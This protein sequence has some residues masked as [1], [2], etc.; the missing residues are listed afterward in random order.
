MSTFM[1]EV[2]DNSEDA[3]E[4]DLL[5]YDKYKEQ[6]KENIIQKFLY[7]NEQKLLKKNYILELVKDT[8]L[9]PYV[10]EMEHLIG[11][12]EGIAFTD[13]PTR[14]LSRFF[15]PKINA[16]IQQSQTDSFLDATNVALGV[17][18][19]F[20]TNYTIQDILNFNVFRYKTK[21]A[22]PDKN[23]LP[24]YV[25]SYLL[26]RNG[27]EPEDNY[28]MFSEVQNKLLNQNITMELLD[29]V[30]AINQI[31]E[32]INNQKEKSNVDSSSNENG[33]TN[34]GN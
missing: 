16:S 21:L 2:F 8:I 27:A 7:L 4:K 3:T 34:N 18:D 20:N 29:R 33:V 31:K 10:L 9:F 14:I 24:I 23:N 32:I 15:F 25:N 1:E 19:I 11:N 5:E 13:E 12:I 26:I 17:N 28:F 22:S 6:N 30:P